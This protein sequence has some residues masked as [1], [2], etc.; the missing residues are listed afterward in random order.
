MSKGLMSS[1]TVYP[2]EAN[3]AFVKIVP[4]GRKITD[5][6]VKTGQR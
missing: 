4:W 5:I 3:A 2:Q 1:N 6:K